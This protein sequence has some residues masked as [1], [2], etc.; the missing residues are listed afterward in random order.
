MLSEARVLENLANRSLFT[1]NFK[2]IY[3]EDR[4]AI[5]RL[6]IESCGS[7]VTL[8]GMLCDEIGRY[9]FANE[10]KVSCDSHLRE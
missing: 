1:S 8:E 10:L 6:G 7:K 2:E 5:V 9:G 4:R 3:L